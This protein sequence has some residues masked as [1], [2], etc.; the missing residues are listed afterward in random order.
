VA[1]CTHR[2]C[3]RTFGGLTGF[4]RHLRWLDI[5]PWLECLDPTEVG[6][7]EADGVWVR[8]GPPV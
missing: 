1:R 8:P 3:G 5:A 4:D 7:S 2:T 6:L